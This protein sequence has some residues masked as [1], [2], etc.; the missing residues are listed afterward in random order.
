VL[1]DFIKLIVTDG[2]HHLVY[3]PVYTFCAGRLGQRSHIT[4]EITL[5]YASQEVFQWHVLEFDIAVRIPNLRKLERLEE[6]FCPLK[7]FF[8][9]S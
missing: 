1:S 4:P 3:G 7:V 5:I 6:R 2:H 8:A 9:R